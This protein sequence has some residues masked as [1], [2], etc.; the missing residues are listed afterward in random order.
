[1]LPSEGLIVLA[2]DE[3]KEDGDGIVKVE[4]ANPKVPAFAAAAFGVGPGQTPSVRLARDVAV[5]VLWR[6]GKNL[7]VMVTK[8]S[9]G[10]GDTIRGQA[11]PRDGRPFPRTRFPAGATGSGRGQSAAAANEDRRGQ[12]PGGRHQVTRKPIMGA[13]MVSEAPGM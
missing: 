5:E 13:G 8:D 6:E 12:R 4:N 3:A 2:V 7:T 11:H 1:M 9:Q 10:G